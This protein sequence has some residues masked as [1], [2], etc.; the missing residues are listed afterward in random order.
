M[1]SP[2]QLDCAKESKIDDQMNIVSQTKKNIS[3]TI[4][5]NIQQNVDM[6]FSNRLSCKNNTFTDLIV[7]NFESFQSLISKACIIS[8]AQRMMRWI[9]MYTNNTLL[10]VLYSYCPLLNRKT[11]NS[12]NISD[13][14]RLYD[15]TY[16][17]SLSCK[18]LAD[19]LKQGMS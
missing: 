5:I 2:S 9:F 13:I 19:W 11:L 8:D 3:I 4:R 15:L 7:W 6:F 12:K 1:K 18:R 14:S 17:G 10:C 16:A